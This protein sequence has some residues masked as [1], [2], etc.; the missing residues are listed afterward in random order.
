[1]PKVTYEVPQ[2]IVEK[3]ILFGKVLK[4]S[5]VLGKWEE[6]FITIDKEGLHS[7]KKC[8]EKEKPTMTIKKGSIK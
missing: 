5:Q 3:A 7:Y 1:M 4:K 6:R 8:S 2:S